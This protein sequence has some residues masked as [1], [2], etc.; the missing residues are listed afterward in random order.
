MPFIITNVFIKNKFPNLILH[1]CIYM[2][3]FFFYCR[4]LMTSVQVPMGKM[5]LEKKIIKTSL[6]NIIVT[7]QH[8]L[9][10]IYLPHAE[11]WDLILI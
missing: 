6:P 11:E 3:A 4:K 10:Y 5:T 2:E 9:P 8:L 1:D 7:T